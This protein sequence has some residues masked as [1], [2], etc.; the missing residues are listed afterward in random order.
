MRYSKWIGV[1]AL[2]VVVL[3]MGIIAATGSS[4]ISIDELSKYTKP[5]A[6]TVQGE[7]ADI[8]IDPQNDLIVFTL[9][10]SSGLIV[11]A[12]YSLSKFQTLYGGLPSHTTV[13]SEIVVRG[14]YYPQRQGNILGYIEVQD[15]LQGCHKAYEAPPV[16]D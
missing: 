13:E 6:V 7:V 3:A 9:R 12:L 5:R 16:K 4:Y 11:H 2:A 8:T 15:I 14:V 1:V 10:G